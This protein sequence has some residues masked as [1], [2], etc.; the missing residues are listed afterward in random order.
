MDLQ[1]HRSSFKK[2]KKKLFQD[3]N[4]EESKQNDV[5]FNLNG[6]QLN[7]QTR[8]DEINS[9]IDNGNELLSQ[10]SPSLN[11]II[12]TSQLSR[13][14][15]QSEKFK[16]LGVEKNEFQDSINESDKEIPTVSQVQNTAQ[17]SLRTR[18]SN[19]LK[20]IFL[21]ENNKKHLQRSKQNLKMVLGLRGSQ[22]EEKKLINFV[23]LKQIH[24]KMTYFFQNF[25]STGRIKFLN[26][27]KHQQ[28]RKA[29][30]DN[31]DYIQPKNK[32]KVVFLIRCFINFLSCFQV[33]KRFF[34]NRS[35]FIIVPNSLFNMLSLVFFCSFNY[36]FFFLLSIIIIY[37]GYLTYEKMIAHFIITTWILDILVQLNTQIYKKTNLISDREKII[38]QYIKNRAIYDMIPLAS[39]FLSTYTFEKAYIQKC[40]Q[41]LSFLKLKNVL[42]DTN[43]MQ[44]QLCM[45]VKNYYIIQLLNLIFKISALS[46]TVACVWYLIGQIELHLLKEE[47]TWY[48]ESIGSDGIWWKLY[49]QSMYWSLTLMITG[50]N[51]AKTT[52]QMFYTSFIMLFT[53]IIFGYMLNTTGIILSQ[54]NQR[55]EEKRKDLNILNDF[56][57]QNK[58]SKG[59]QGRVN[60][61]LEYQYL[62]NLKKDQEQKQ[63]VISKISPHL[64]RLLKLEQTKSALE[65]F[66]FLNKNFSKETIQDL[67][68]EFN[69]EFYSPNQIVF[70]DKQANNLSLIL[71]LQGSLQICQTIDK[72]TQPIQ[73]LKEGDVIGQINFFTGLQFEYSV[74]SV[75]FTKVIKLDREK[76][77]E[78]IQKREKDYEKFC[79]IRDKQQFY[80]QYNIVQVK[81]TFCHQYTHQTT[82]CNLVHMDRQS[83]VFV[84]KFQQNFC[85]SRLKY[86]RK[87]IN[88]NSYMIRIA[89]QQSVSK[90]MFE[91]KKALKINTFIQKKNNFPSNDSDEYES[92]NSIRMFSTFQILSSQQSSEEE[93]EQSAVTAQKVKNSRYFQSNK[94]IQLNQN[95][96][97][98]QKSQEITS[99]KDIGAQQAPPIN[100]IQLEIMNKYQDQVNKRGSIFKTKNKKHRN[101][102]Q[103]IDFNKKNNNQDAENFSKRHS[104]L[105]QNAIMNNNTYYNQNDDS[106]QVKSKQRITQDFSLTPSNS[107]QKQGIQQLQNTSRLANSKKRDK[108]SDYE[109][110]FRS[111]QKRK[112]SILQKPMSMMQILE[113]EKN[114]K[115][116]IFDF[117]LY[118]NWMVYFPQGNLVNILNKYNKRLRKKTKHLTFYDKKKD[119]VEKKQVE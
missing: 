109:N 101:S 8:R 97:K 87:Q 96:L 80:M 91:E 20:S 74:K 16:T 41:V 28:I 117:D 73:F 14:N 92:E 103:V 115:L 35:C 11:Q 98:K 65:K 48:D 67:S 17:R 99:L 66:N 88:Q 72:Q 105:Y 56:M 84:A 75:D 59:L 102:I 43:N 89:V 31:G 71:I 33:F 15:I 64:Q 77:L 112:T 107:I 60:L 45:S 3:Q 25:T 85:Q 21:S 116:F 36:L 4:F 54:L 93:N 1:N 19:H 6:L 47:T 13:T 38:S 79:Y 10:G 30:N 37:Q 40:L 32:D 108:K 69:E 44:K 23:L 22:T 18:S 106:Q 5:T 27:E 55:D 70:T 29:I 51:E 42:K 111:A 78:I 12:Q 113:E 114:Q 49:L 46:H 61:D 118:K 52:A 34:Q 63:E 24:Q 110:H 100:L 62:H 95:S 57:R 9:L 68:L 76:F 81:C 53:A 86:V 50:S 26:N 119:K 2:E 58:I 39:I 94:I 7:S 82:E 104:F 90:Y 83:S